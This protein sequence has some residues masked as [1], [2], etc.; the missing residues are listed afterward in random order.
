VL[1]RF[2]QIFRS[3][4]DRWWEKVPFGVGE[5][6]EVLSIHT[7][8]HYILNGLNRRWQING[9]VAG[10]DRLNSAVIIAIFFYF[11]SLWILIAQRHHKNWSS[12]EPL[13]YWMGLSFGCGLNS[14]LQ[15]VAR[16]DTLTF[17]FFS[18][19][20]FLFLFIA[21]LNFLLVSKNHLT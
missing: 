10:F 13:M 18:F 19:L 4:S 21:V 16:V 15:S 11:L 7:S 2:G 3:L 6:T 14:W 9:G 5:F 12:C 20:S 17:P 1:G 8:R